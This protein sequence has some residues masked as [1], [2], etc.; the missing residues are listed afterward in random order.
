MSSSSSGLGVT[1]A[2]RLDRRLVDGRRRCLS[3]H[4]R[5]VLCAARSRPSS[6]SPARHHP[7]RALR[8]SQLRD[9]DPGDAGSARRRACRAFRPPGCSGP[10]ILADGADGGARRPRRL[11]RARHSTVSA[12]GARFD[13]E[14]DAA[15]ILV[16]STLVVAAR[17]GRL[18]GAALRV[19][20][21]RV[22][23]GGT[24]AAVA[25]QAAAGNAARQDRGHYPTVRA[26]ALRS[27][28]LF[29]RPAS[30]VAAVISLAALCWSFGIDVAWLWRQY[31]TS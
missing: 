12:Y 31:R 11:A 5:R 23:R 10:V 24:G 18:L 4:G 29:P 9:D 7:F 28:R 19:H 26:R 6:R 14:T 2:S 25:C 16:L 22:R 3:A 17:K 1:A 15:F 21:L 13:M 20:A 30:D 27:R 8:A